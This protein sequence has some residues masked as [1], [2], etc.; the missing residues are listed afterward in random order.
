MSQVIF[1]ATD[2]YLKGGYRSYVD[3]FRL[4]ELSGYPIIPLSQ[5]DPNSDN[6]YIITPLNGEWLNGW[7]NPRARIIHWELEWRTD[8]RAEV[9]E[10][11]GVAEVWASD[12]W[13]ATQIGA[14]YVPVGGNVNLNESGNYPEYPVNYDVSLLSYQTHRRQVVT[15]QLENAGLR[16]APISNLWGRQR[17]ITLLQSH[18]MVHVHQHDHMPTVAPLRL[19]LAAAHRLP[20]ISETIR[21]AGIFDYRYMMQARYETLASFSAHVLSDKHILA[22]YAYSLYDLLCVQ[23]VFKRVVDANV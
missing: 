16:L 9:N 4:V 1:C 19:C 12:K 7:T 11:P 23:Q 20:L 6:T 3:F 21:D 22:D 14:R 13:Y 8:W 17:S 2:F 5:L 10:P 18:A 15:A